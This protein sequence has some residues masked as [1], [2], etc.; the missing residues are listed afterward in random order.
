MPRGLNSSW[1]PEMKSL[2]TAAAAGQEAVGVVAAGGADG[3]AESDEAADA[4]VAAAGAQADV[5][6]EAEAG[7]E[8]RQLVGAVEPVEAGA[9]VVDFAAPI[10]VRA[11][12]KAGT[13]EV[14][15]QHGQ[16]EVREGLGGVVHRLGVHGAAAERVRVRHDGGVE[17]LGRTGVEDRLKPAAGAAEV[18]D[19]LD[20]GAKGFGHLCI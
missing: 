17:R 11:F 3:Q 5:G 4:G 18:F 15:A 12:A 2:G 14:E 20:V 6:A 19:R 7:E 16:A 9:D 8:D 1:S 13:A 10:V